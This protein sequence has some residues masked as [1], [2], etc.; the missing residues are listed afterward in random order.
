MNFFE[1]EYLIV[2]INTRTSRGPLVASIIASALAHGGNDYEAI[3][4][5]VEFHSIPLQEQRIISIE[6]AIRL[7]ALRNTSARTNKKRHIAKMLLTDLGAVT[8]AKWAARLKV[9]ETPLGIV[10]DAAEFLARF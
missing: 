7:E 8:V 6:V 9:M 2:A 3:D 5:A 4:F 1:P 10:F